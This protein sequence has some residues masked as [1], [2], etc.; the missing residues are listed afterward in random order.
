MSRSLQR[1]YPGHVLS[2]VSA[3]ATSACSVCDLGRR[4]LAPF[5][6]LEPPIGERPDPRAPQLLHRMADRFAHPAH[7][8]VASFADRERQHAVAIVPAAALQQRST[9]AGSVRRPSSGMPARSRSS[10][11][12]VRHA[13]DAR[14]VGA[15]DAVAR[16]RQPRREVAV[17]GQQQQ[18]L[19]VVVEPAD[20]VDVLADAAEQIDHRPPA[21]RIRRAS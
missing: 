13:G 11:S 6:G 3:P 12:L 18:P 19:G 7:L 10:A 17:V 21:L 5:T 20:R 8:A 15:L 16:M 1:T 2:R 4:Q 9:S 14:L